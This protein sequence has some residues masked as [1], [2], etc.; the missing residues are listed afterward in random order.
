MTLFYL[1]Q[2]VWCA[3][4]ACTVF[5][6][7]VV[8]FSTSAQESSCKIDEK[9][10]IGIICDDFSMKI[11]GRAQID[12]LAFSA[13][14]AEG[15]L[16]DPVLQGRSSADIRRVRLGLQ[17][18]Y[19]GALKAFKF[20]YDFVSST[21]IKDLRIDISLEPFILRLGH[22]KV[23]FS[24]AEQTSS[25]F[26]QFIERPLADDN[27]AIP[28]RRM[29]VGLFSKGRAWTWGGVLHT[30]SYREDSNR[31]KSLFGFGTRVTYA[32]WLDKDKGNLVH[33]GFGWRVASQVEGNPSQQDFDGHTPFSS[34]VLGDD[35]YSVS[36]LGLES[37]NVFNP[38]VAFSWGSLGMQAEY[39]G[40]LSSAG[41][42]R[43]EDELSMNAFYVQGYVW[44]TGEKHP[45]KDGEFK[46]VKPVKP[47][48]KGGLGAFGVGVR[49]QNTAFE[50]DDKSAAN[51]DAVDDSVNAFSIVANWKPDPYVKLTFE[52]A[53][54]T[55]EI[56]NYTAASGDDPATV[57]ILKTK[58]R[59]F[60]MRLGID[61]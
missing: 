57:R 16:P 59:A 61:W 24:L 56:L 28:G 33:L 11:I 54:A 20:E 52:Y 40:L 44:L 50:T 21:A 34:A 15:S 7:I 14:D 3:L 29:G 30:D 51:A 36:G 55:R 39:Y 46:R 26:Y 38:E 12:Y 41:E 5:A 58:P 18:S 35:I 49:Y 53:F 60:Q 27:A 45:Y 8:P 37:Y 31:T 42:G 6:F 22:F 25:R 43:D 17:G 4:F 23:P 10:R 19:G 32:P 48:A 9:A 13:D 47:F 2:R 1:P